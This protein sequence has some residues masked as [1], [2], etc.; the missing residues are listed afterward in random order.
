M[1]EVIL[2]NVTKTFGTH[3]A[4]DDVSMTIPDG[5]FV[6]LLGPTGAGKTTTLRMVSG[7]DTPNSGEI[8]IG[9]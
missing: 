9:G 6:V 8:F 3:T 2:R 7:L 4:L 1:A 5:S